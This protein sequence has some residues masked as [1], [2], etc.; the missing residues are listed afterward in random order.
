MEPYV[1]IYSG[2]VG[3]E[4]FGVR[5]LRHRVSFVGCIVDWQTHRVRLGDSGIGAGGLFQLRSQEMD[6]LVGILCIIVSVVAIA[7]AGCAAEESAQSPREIL[8]NTGP[9]P[10]RFTL[11]SVVDVADVI[12][13]VEL[14]SV[15]TVGE[16]IIGWSSE[17]TWYGKAL[18]HRFRVLEYLKGDGGQEIVVILASGTEDDTQWHFSTAEEAKELGPD[19][20]ELR[21]SEWDDREA[22]LF[23]RHDIPWLPSTK[24]DNTYSLGF[25]TEYSGE[26]WVGTFDSE[27]MRRWLPIARAGRDREL[28]NGYPKEP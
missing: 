14:L 26:G 11:D 15:T 27:I 23:A 13:R 7:V 5:K 16:P 25:Y 3:R 24:M 1:T 2:A 17:G 4:R 6:R 10:Q 20:M 28:Y 21:S 12:A 19:L 9:G 18:H 8:G 22:I